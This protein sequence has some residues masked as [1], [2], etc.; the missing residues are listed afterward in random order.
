M[1]WVFELT[2]GWPH[3]GALHRLPAN[4]PYPYPMWFAW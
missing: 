1:V 3:N 4:K 2:S